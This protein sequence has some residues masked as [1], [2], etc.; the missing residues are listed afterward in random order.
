MLGC[1]CEI[2]SMYGVAQEKS[3]NLVSAKLIFGGILLV[4]GIEWHAGQ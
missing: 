1:L 4:D 2:T 3:A